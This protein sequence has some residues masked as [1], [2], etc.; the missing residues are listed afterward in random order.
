[1]FGKLGEIGNLMKQA[2]QMKAKMQEMREQAANM[3]FE[4]DSG[5]GMVKATVNGALELV[6]IKISPEA[7]SGGDVEMLEDLI[8]AA[9]A[10][11]QKKASDGMRAEMAKLTG[12]LNIPG[13]DSM[14]GG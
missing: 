14:M 2:G 3:R 10:A 6:S 4:A 12:G 9:V 8:R 1:M 5:A 13:L 11:G 7:I